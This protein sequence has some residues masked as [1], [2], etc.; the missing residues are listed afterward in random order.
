V[1]FGVLAEANFCLKKSTAKHAGEQ[2]LERSATE[3]EGERGCSKRFAGTG[4][5]GSSGKFGVKRIDFTPQ[6]EA[7]Y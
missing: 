3:A 1:G 2:A 6:V 5:N 7:R 4:H